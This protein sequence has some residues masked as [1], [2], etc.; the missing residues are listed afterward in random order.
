MLP[1]Y[2]HQLLNPSVLWFGSQQW[3]LTWTLLGSCLNL[4][5]CWNTSG[6]IMNPTSYTDKD[7]HSLRAAACRTPPQDPC[8]APLV[9]STRDCTWLVVTSCAFCPFAKRHRWTHYLKVIDRLSQAYFIER[10]VEGWNGVWA[11][12]TFEAE[13]A[14]PGHGH[15]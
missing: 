9:L 14:A 10:G 4:G 6:R 11:P 13:S 3:C 8:H 7:V 5:G 12:E 15:L 2:G 1:L